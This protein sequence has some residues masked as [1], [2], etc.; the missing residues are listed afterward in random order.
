MHSIRRSLWKRGTCPIEQGVAA[1]NP[2][3]VEPRTL[4][5]HQNVDAAGT[6][7]AFRH[8]LRL[9]IGAA[10]LVIVI[11]AGVAGYL[12]KWLWMRQLDYTGIFWTILSVQWAMFGSAFALAFLYLWINLRQAAK[13]GGFHGD[14]QARK[15]TFSSTT[16]AGTRTIIELPPGL[17]NLAVILIS[18]GV[19]LFLASGFNSGWDLY[20]RFRYGGLFG[21]SSGFMFFTCPSIFCCKAA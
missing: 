1:I 21:I 18:G 19:A 7:A 8:P 4:A 10:V 3:I 9:I 12:E 16:G 14:G 17:L 11:L 6:H 2:P 13:N 15:F 5:A 20:L